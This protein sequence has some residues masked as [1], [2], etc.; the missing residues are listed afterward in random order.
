MALSHVLGQS[1]NDARCGVNS[2]LVEEALLVGMSIQIDGAVLQ[3]GLV[4]SSSKAIR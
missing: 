3:G 2:D 4:A 1:T